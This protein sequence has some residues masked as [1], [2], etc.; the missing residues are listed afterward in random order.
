MWKSQREIATLTCQEWPTTWRKMYVEF[1]LKWCT[2]CFLR[3]KGQLTDP[4]CF[5]SSPF[6]LQ[7]KVLP[8]FQEQKSF[9]VDANGQDLQMETILVYYVDEE[10]PTFTMKSLSGGII[11]VIV[12]VVLAVV[13]GLLALVSALLDINVIKWGTAEV[14]FFFLFPFEVSVWI[15]IFFL[16]L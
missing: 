9:T 2:V 14:F 11:A 8:L 1:I 3:F 12:V 4:V 5:P 15:L 10:P 7:V 13:I 6:P 16:C